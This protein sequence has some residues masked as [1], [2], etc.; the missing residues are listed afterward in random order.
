MNQREMDRPLLSDA[1]ESAESWWTQ[2]THMRR[3]HLARKLLAAILAVST[4]GALLA[5]LTELALDYHHDVEQVHAGLDDL[6]KTTVGTMAYN[7]WMVNPET[8]RRQM[9]DLLRLPTVQ[10]VEV[11]END[12]THYQAGHPVEPLRDRVDRTF[13]LEY[14]HPVS[15][16]TLLMG[17]VRIESSTADI[18]SRLF[19]R[20]LVIL[21]TQGLKTF[22]VSF[23]ILAF[24]QWLVT[25]HLR[26]I[27]Q[28]ARRIN[29]LNLRE[30]LRLDRE[31]ENDELNELV[32]AFN[33]MRRNL[34]RDIELW[35]GN[36][37]ALMA[38][39]G[40][41]LQALNAV[42]EVMLRTDNRSVVAAMNPLAEQQLGQPALT[43]RPLSEV[44][45]SVPGYVNVAAERIF[46]ELQGMRA[47]LRRRIVFRHRD[48]RILASE[49]SAM[50]MR[51]GDQQVQGMVLLLADLHDIQP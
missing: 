22:L 16:H 18:K 6:Q 13:K 40:S 1:A 5:T 42:P 44:L 12:G 15:G 35:E 24:F 45:P 27:T 30:P 50:L 32:N 29:Y 20:F 39:N 4:L 3:S 46:L 48:G 7:L 47:P 26:N 10:F 37:K 21:C 51:D 2:L 14:Q 25:R 23:F 31:P 34:L 43:G 9:A 11:V 19:D 38:E 41:N 8:L 36:E 49:A 17:T 28:Q 33:H